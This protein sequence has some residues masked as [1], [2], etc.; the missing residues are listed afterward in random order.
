MYDVGLDQHSLPAT[1]QLLDGLLT[2]G[3][4]VLVLTLFFN[5]GWPSLRAWLVRGEPTPDPWNSD[6]ERSI[7]EDDATDLCH[8]C[9]TPQESTAWFCPHCN[10]SVGPYNNY[11]PFLKE[12]AIG[13]VLRSGSFGPTAP[14]LSVIIGAGVLSALLFGPFCVIYWHRLLNRRDQAAGTDDSHSS[15][16][17]ESSKGRHGEPDSSDNRNQA[18]E[19]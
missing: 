12:F 5:F 8:R 15:H 3:L 7:H 11:M 2:L 13:E 19:Q 17:E 4:T 10:A 1:E 18:S 9:F 6:V 14:R 16:A